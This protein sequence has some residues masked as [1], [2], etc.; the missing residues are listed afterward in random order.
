MIKVEAKRERVLSND[1]IV[2]LGKER[3]QLRI[4]IAQMLTK[5]FWENI[6]WVFKFFKSG[7]EALGSG[8]SFDDSAALTALTTFSHVDKNY[9]YTLPQEPDQV[10]DQENGENGS[11]RDDNSGGAVSMRSQATEI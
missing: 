6:L 1:K 4:K 11:M 2:R 8:D 10:V 7:D 5:K 3:L 9:T